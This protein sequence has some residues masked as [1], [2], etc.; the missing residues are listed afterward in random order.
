MDM[1]FCVKQKK[2]L[3]GERHMIPLVWQCDTALV[4]I[5]PSLTGV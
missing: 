3:P 1:K 2:K 4:H 5:T